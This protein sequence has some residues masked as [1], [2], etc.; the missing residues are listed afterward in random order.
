MAGAKR[1]VSAAR[2]ASGGAQGPAR[3]AAPLQ[4]GR[5]VT[6][7]LD[8]NGHV[9]VERLTLRLGMSKA[10]L[11]EAVGLQQD[12]LYRAARLHRPKPQARLSE[13]L[14]IVGRIAGW[15][16]GE[17]Q[18]LAWYRAEPIPSFGGRTAEALV[19]EGK[20]AAV[21]DY[22]DRVATGGFA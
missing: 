14:E 4:G 2:P 6:T 17:R 5:F 15:A 8:E 3:P 7:F 21:R 16:G 22:L 20:A 12:V 1:S 18:A 13:M 11:A 10:Q 19:K 9:A